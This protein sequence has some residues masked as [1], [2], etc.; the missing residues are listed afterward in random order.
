VQENATEC[1]RRCPGR[2]PESKWRFE[3]EVEVKSKGG[4]SGCKRIAPHPTGHLM[5]VGDGQVRVSTETPISGLST[6]ISADRVND[7]FRSV[8]LHP[9]FLLSP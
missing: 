6:L 1:Q 8:V 9:S 4:V 7:L 3:L 5:S 2:V